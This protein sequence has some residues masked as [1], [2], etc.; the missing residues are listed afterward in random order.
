MQE[1]LPLIALIVSLAVA[2]INALALTQRATVS[3]VDG[4][5]R[6]VAALDE[7]QKHA[8]SM[9]SV[10]ELS[11]SL[12]ELAA[13]VRATNG[14]VSQLHRRFDQYEAAILREAS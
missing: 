7:R 5:E 8:P 10:H 12:R 13:E 3:R 6:Q 1:A 14:G 11:S 9:Q 2:I 4:L